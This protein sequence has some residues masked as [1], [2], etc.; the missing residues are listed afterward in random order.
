MNLICE[1]ERERDLF[2]YLDEG[3][4]DPRLLKQGDPDVKGLKLP[5]NIGGSLYLNG[6]E[7]G[8]S[9]LMKQYKLIARQH[10]A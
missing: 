5:E 2:D 1:T 10:R 8:Y 4:I 3:E 9:E 6:N 7:N